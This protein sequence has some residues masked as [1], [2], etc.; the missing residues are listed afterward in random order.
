M[1][2][3][4][5]VKMELCQTVP[6]DRERQHAQ[7]YGMLLFGR[8]FGYQQI[9]M[10]TE[11]EQV[12]TLCASL[13][14]TL[15]SLRTQ[16][17]ALAHPKGRAFF[18]IE[19]KEDW[20]ARLFEYFGY[21]PDIISLRI[22]RANMGTEESLRDFVR[23]AFLSCGTVINPDKD[24]HLEFAVPHLN[25]G[26]DL[27]FLLKEQGFSPKYVR[28]GGKY[29]LYF[30]DSAQIE[31]V[32]TY[33]GAVRQSL[34]LMN[35]KVYRDLRNTANRVT[36][37]ETANIDKTVN[38]A[39]EQVA[40]IRKL[41]KNGRYDRLPGQLHEVARLRLAHPEMSL[42]ELGT[43]LSEPLSRSGINHRLKRIVA[44]AKEQ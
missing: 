25:L 21:A 19:L 44:F 42:R 20:A 40:A 18:E 10:R 38:A 5:D 22:N 17:Q 13:I 29:V 24:Y 16:A 11:H 39:A 23:G 8:F 43:L 36:N 31:D 33:M 14:Q 2:Y 41:M 37:C 32:L 7:L 35:L 34:E 1:S 3:A 30:K 6:P 26:K 15:F 28:R 4:Y 9:L 27:L 12:A